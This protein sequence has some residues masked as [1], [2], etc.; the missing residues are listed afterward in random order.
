L[1]RAATFAKEKMGGGVQHTMGNRSKGIAGRNGKV[2]FAYKHYS[3]KTNCF[4]FP[5]KVGEKN[6]AGNQQA[7]QKKEIAPNETSG[8]CHAKN[9]KWGWK[10]FHIKLNYY[11]RRS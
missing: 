10:T 7:R 4:F 6:N 11:Q 5:R 8:W 3:T 2:S 1:K 9:T